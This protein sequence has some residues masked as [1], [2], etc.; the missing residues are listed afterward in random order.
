[1]TITPEQKQ[2]ILKTIKADID[3]RGSR[4]LLWVMEFV[5]GKKLEGSNDRHHLE[6]LS[7]KLIENGKYVRRKLVIKHSIGYTYQ[8]FKN[9]QYATNKSIKIATWVVAVATVINLGV[10]IFN[11]SKSNKTEKPLIYIVSSKK[12]SLKIDSLTVPK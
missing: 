8:I 10:T 3:E 1:M 11:A 5:C 12:D 2:A 9:P 7:G 4:N 6:E